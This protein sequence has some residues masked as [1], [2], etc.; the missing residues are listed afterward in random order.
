V[1]GRCPWQRQSPAAAGSKKRKKGRLRSS[2]PPRPERPRLHPASGFATATPDRSRGKGPW[3]GPDDHGHDLRPHPVRSRRH[4]CAPAGHHGATVACSGA[5]ASQIACDGN[6]VGPIQMVKGK[7]VGMGT[8][9]RHGR[10]DNRQRNG[11]CYRRPWQPRP[12]N[13]VCDGP[14]RP[15]AERRV[16]SEECRVKSAE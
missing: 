10:Q 16:Q 15:S 7:A 14:R 2:R 3:K 12:V 8:L 1:A 13:R 6:D 9:R 4:G 11:H 5:P